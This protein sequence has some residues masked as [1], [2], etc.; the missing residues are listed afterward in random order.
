MDGDA[1]AG[2]DA[3]F[4]ELTGLLEGARVT[5]TCT[6]PNVT[7]TFDFTLGAA[8]AVDFPST[9]RS[10]AILLATGDA[11]VAPPVAEAISRGV[12]M[13]DVT[14][15]CLAELQALQGDVSYLALLCQVPADA[16]RLS[17]FTLDIHADADSSGMLRAEAAQMIGKSDGTSLCDGT[18][19]GHVFSYTFTLGATPTNL[20]VNTSRTVSGG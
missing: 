19:A 6:G 2:A 3:G 5:G 14:I 4:S 11:S 18:L 9:G 7:A 16:P 12:A 20:V 17:T 15:P 8:A 13:Q 10:G 1:H